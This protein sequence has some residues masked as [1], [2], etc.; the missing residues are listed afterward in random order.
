VGAGRRGAPAKGL[1]GGGGPVSANSGG[2][3]LKTREVKNGG[4]VYFFARL[5]RIYRT[6]TPER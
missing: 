4:P 5:I 2:E 6:K 1:E 3:V